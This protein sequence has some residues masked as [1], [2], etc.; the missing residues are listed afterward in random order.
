[1]KFSELGQLPFQLERLIEGC[2]IEMALV[3]NSAHYYQ[4]CRLK[5]NNTKFV[6]AEKRSRVPKA[7]VPVLPACKHSR[8]RSTEDC[9][10]KNVCFFCGEASGNSGMHE[11]ATS[12]QEIGK[13]FFVWRAIRLNFLSF[14]QGFCLYHSV[15]KINNLLSLKM[16]LLSAS[17][18][19]KIWFH[20]LHVAMRRQILVCCSMQIMQ[21]TMF[22]R[23][24]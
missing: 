19:C 3:A 22:I 12:F 21:H 2:G 11:A 23:I 14:C 15:K 4:S 16:S 9:A 5:F 10:T 13:D 7:D 17:L 18:C 8:S 20:Y 1:M 6:R 24:L